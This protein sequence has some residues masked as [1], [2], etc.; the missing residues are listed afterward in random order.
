M[1]NIKKTLGIIDLNN[2]QDDEE[3]LLDIPY[4][5]F[6]DKVIKLFK[7]GSYLQIRL[8]VEVLSK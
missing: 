4:E 8:M 2:L 3:F 1:A 6:E 5:M 7:K